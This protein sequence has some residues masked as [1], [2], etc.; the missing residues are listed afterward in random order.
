MT[1]TKLLREQVQSNGLK[2]GFIAKKLNLSA[3]GLKRKIE[4]TNEF[5]ASEIVKLCE[6]LGLDDKMR[7]KIFFAV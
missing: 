3:C 4:N 6:I 7:D 2:Y 5:K 1:N